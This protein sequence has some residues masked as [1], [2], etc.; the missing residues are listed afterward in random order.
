MADT[1]I[2]ISGPSLLS[3]VEMDAFQHTFVGR[4]NELLYVFEKKASNL[5]EIIK[6]IEPYIDIEKAYVQNFEKFI[7][8]NKN[9]TGAGSLQGSSNLFDPSFDAK[10]S[11]TFDLF[12][13]WF[14]ILY[15]SSDATLKK[16]RAAKED[17]EKFI[18]DFDHEK[19]KVPSFFYYFTLPLL[20]FFL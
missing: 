10:L 9:F 17:L 18:D 20:L 6:I 14:S 13:H 16:F 4:Y 7:K 15:S 3:E 5:S 19:K 1:K 2:P 12:K 11:E 8:Q